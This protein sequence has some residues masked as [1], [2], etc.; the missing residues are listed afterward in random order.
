MGVVLYNEK[1][2]RENA[3]FIMVHVSIIKYHLIRQSD[4]LNSSYYYYYY[5]VLLI[6]KT[7]P[8]RNNLK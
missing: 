5:Y 4:E 7:P 2:N 8:L 3:F 1:W 6:E